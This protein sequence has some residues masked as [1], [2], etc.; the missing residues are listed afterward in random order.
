MTEI[1][2]SGQDYEVGPIGARRPAKSNAAI[3]VG[4]LDGDAARKQFESASLSTK[5]AGI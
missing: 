4:S 5:N 1:Y 2:E 3:D